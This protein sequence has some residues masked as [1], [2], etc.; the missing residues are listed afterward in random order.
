MPNTS[1]HFPAGML[2]ELDRL[3]AEA[4]VSRNS[5]IV[6]SCRHALKARRG[7]PE[8]FFSDDHLTAADR[9]ELKRSLR[10]FTDALVADRHNRRRPPF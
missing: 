2:D 10:P 1:V 3:A 6:E 7:W 5:V 9:R 8:A 4:G